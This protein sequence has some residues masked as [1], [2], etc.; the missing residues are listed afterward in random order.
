M[1]FDFDLGKTD[2]KA[3][4]AGKIKIEFPKYTQRLKYIQECQF[5]LDESGEIKIS[6]DSVDSIVKM[7]EIA[8]GHVKEVDVTHIKTGY[9]FTQFEDLEDFQD[10]QEI[11]N[12]IAG[13][14]LGGIQLGEV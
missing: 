4:W 8:R 6:V 5:K 7:I 9:V 10:C 13:K 3:T 12:V 1:I 2:M 11:I 14:I